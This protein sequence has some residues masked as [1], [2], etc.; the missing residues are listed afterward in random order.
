MS[1]FTADC[2][3]TVLQ[4]NRLV[5]AAVVLRFAIWSGAPT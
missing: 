1:I 2:T 4:V 5:N 3:S